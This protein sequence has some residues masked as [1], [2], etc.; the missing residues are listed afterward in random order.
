MTLFV[1]VGDVEKRVPV[2]SGL[3]EIVS[4]ASGPTEFTRTVLLSDPPTLNFPKSM[5]AADSVIP[6]TSEDPADAVKLPTMPM[7]AWILH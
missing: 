5:D 4:A 2:E 1:V 3:D 7:A 6:F